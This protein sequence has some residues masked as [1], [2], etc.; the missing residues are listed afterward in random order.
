M[1]VEQS[2]LVLANP[3]LDLRAYPTTFGVMP[4]AN[5]KSLLNKGLAGIQEIFGDMSYEVVRQLAGAKDFAAELASKQNQTAQTRESWLTLVDMFG[6]PDESNELVVST[7]VL[8][9]HHLNRTE[10]ALSQAEKSLAAALNQWLGSIRETLIM[11][12]VKKQMAEAELTASETQLQ[13]LNLAQT[14]YDANLVAPDDR[15]LA[16]GRK[17][18]VKAQ[19]A[20]L[21][22]KIKSLRHE[23]K[24]MQANIEGLGNLTLAT[25]NTIAAT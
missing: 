20:A 2:G 11:E 24:E 9:R 14:N 6:A 4:E 18:K 16:I 17:A 1:S 5:P 25:M 23:L 19:V 22:D 12:A 3:N 7:W 8:L 13:E 15:E 21:K 10:T